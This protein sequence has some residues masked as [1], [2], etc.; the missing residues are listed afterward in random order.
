M[1]N[2]QIFKEIGFPNKKNEEWKF[3]DLK[4]I[5]EK[6][7]DKIDNKKITSKI[8]K[9][10]LLNNF[11]H[12]Y[13]FLV[14]GNLHSSNFDYEDKSK[15]LIGQINDQTDYQINKNPL[16]CLNHALAEKGY[17]LEVKKNYKFNKSLVIYNF[18]TA[19][20]K[21]KI[22]NNKNKIII[23]EYSDVHII[24]YTINESKYKFINNSYEEV[25]LKKN[26]K[27]KNLYIQKKKK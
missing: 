21:N 27:I 16:V 17:S 26:S 14:N 1:K 23:N 5:I 11:E 9:I 3:S 18:F 8:N 25:I 15:I 22:L 24:E 4:N 6:N 13:I 12:N 2:L 10:N 19:D 7:F 20:L